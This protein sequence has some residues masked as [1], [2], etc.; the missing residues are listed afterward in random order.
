MQ[1]TE[2][3]R[4]DEFARLLGIELTEVAPG[5]ARVEMKIGREHLNGIQ[6]AHGAAI[7][8]LADC[9]F[10]VASNSHGRVSLGITAAISFLEAAGE[11]LL[12]A[13]AREVGR[14]RK[15]ATYQV[16]VTDEEGRRIALFQGTVYRKQ[17]K[18]A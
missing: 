18:L 1:V 17:E 15:L 7:F 13:E 10:A 11:G 3:F 4:R 14:N 12:V 2:F 16:E 8:A 5:F 9:A 6:I